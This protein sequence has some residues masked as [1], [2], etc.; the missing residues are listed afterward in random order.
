M[1]SKVVLAGVLLAMAAPTVEGQTRREPQPRQDRRIELPQ[2]RVSTIGVRLSDVTADSMKTLKLSRV[3]GAVV[4][5]VNANSPAAAANVRE[6]DVIVVFDGERV[7]SASHLT[8]LVHETPVDR[9]VV[10]AVMR[11]G[12]RTELRITP[13]ASE[14][15]WFD[16]RFGDLINSEEVRRA[17][18]EA[19]RELGRR[20]PEAMEGM[21]DGM[22]LP[23]RGRLGANVQPLSADLAEYFGAKSGVLVSSVASDS[24]AAKAGLRA[25]DVITAIDGKAVASPR[26]LVNALPAGEGTHDVTLTIVRDKKEMTLKATLGAPAAVRK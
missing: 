10:M 2:A 9:E 17:V 13:V 4:E 7:R 6:K 8:R 1:S 24:A 21:R 20:L 19:R 23:N 3:E 25:G 22:A 11:E 18:E 12:R 16:P 5:F 14:A 15:G 26:D